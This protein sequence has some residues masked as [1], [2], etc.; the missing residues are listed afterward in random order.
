M[1][2]E[3][4]TSGGRVARVHGMATVGGRGD[5]QRMAKYIINPIKKSRN[6]KY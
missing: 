5:P 4:W 3:G 2:D 1:A 6:Q